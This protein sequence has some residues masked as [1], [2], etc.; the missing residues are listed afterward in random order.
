MAESWRRQLDALYTRGAAGYNDQY[1]RLLTGDRPPIST[2]STT[3][4]SAVNYAPGGIPR[5]SAGPASYSSVSLPVTSTI[6]SRT[7]HPYTKVRDSADS[8]MLAMPALR[9]IS[10]P[11]NLTHRGSSVPDQHSDRLY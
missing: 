11:G 10:D 8:N 3:S 1:Q 4:A 6:D 2:T 5:C 9:E 7:A